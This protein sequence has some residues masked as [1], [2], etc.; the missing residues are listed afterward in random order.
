MANLAQQAVSVHPLIALTVFAVTLLAPEALARG[1]TVI[2]MPAPEL[3]VISVQLLTRIVSAALPAVTPEIVPE[4]DMPADITP[5]GSRIALLVWR[6][7]EPE[8]ALTKP[9][10]GMRGHTD[11]LA[12]VIAAP[13]ELAEL[14]PVIYMLTVA[15]GAP[16]KAAM[17]AGTQQP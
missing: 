11:A 10:T 7:T 3:A 15:A 5:A 12:L 13:E 1:A 17:L 6:A 14:V 16:A 4:Q 9:Q 2:L 8:P